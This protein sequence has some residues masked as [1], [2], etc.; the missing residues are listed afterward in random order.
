MLTTIVAASTFD[1]ALLLLLGFILSLLSPNA[2]HHLP[3]E[4][5]KPAVAGQVHA[6]V[7]RHQVE[8][9]IQRRLG[10]TFHLFDIVQPPALVEE[11]FFGSVETREHFKAPIRISG[12]PV[13]LAGSRWH[14]TE[15]EV[16]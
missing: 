6:D 2:P 3:A 15:V 16:D 7:M 1:S 9:A 14:R 11:R 4:A 12:H 8:L 13:P 5:A 10:S